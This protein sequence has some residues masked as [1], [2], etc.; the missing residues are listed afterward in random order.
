MRSLSG[1]VAK[2]MPEGFLKEEI[3][4]LNTGTSRSV[5]GEWARGE[6]ARGQSFM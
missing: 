6:W 3:P 5:Q 4:E 1:G 2:K